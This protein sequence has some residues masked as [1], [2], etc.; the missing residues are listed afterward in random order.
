MQERL[1]ELLLDSEVDAQRLCK[2]NVTT[3]LHHLMRHATEVMPAFSIA[4]K[5]LD[6]GVDPDA[7]SSYY[8]GL[9]PLEI[10]VG[11]ISVSG[12]NKPTELSNFCLFSLLL[13]RKG[14]NLNR[15]RSNGGTI[16]HLVVCG[17][18]NFL[19]TR[20]DPGYIAFKAGLLVI[21]LLSQGVDPAIKD[22]DS[23]TPAELAIESLIRAVENETFSWLKDT[24]QHWVGMIDILREGEKFFNQGRRIGDLINDPAARKDFF[25]SMGITD[26]D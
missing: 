25:R 22:E 15:Q 9:T 11:I 8:G 3:P 1:V 23:D 12:I 17:A 7:V 24:R 4:E 14:A 19:A 18:R 13:R 10:L 21:D 20:S 16:L 26:D 6:A 5:L 2:S